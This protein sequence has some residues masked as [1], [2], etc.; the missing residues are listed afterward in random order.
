MHMVYAQFAKMGRFEVRTDIP[1]HGLN[2]LKEFEGL[3]ARKQRR[4]YQYVVSF[5]ASTGTI[6]IALR[7]D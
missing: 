1:I 2:E 3:E 7:C 6:M 4:M 5:C